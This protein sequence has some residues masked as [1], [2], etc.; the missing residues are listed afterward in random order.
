[1]FYQLIPL[2]IFLAVLLI[3]GVALI[4]DAGLRLMRG[5]RR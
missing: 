5:E 4:A 2:L 1:M 3:V